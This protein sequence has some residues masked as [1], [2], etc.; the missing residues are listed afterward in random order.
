MPLPGTGLI[1]VD[2]QFVN[3][4]EMNYNYLETSGCIDA[5]NPDLFDPDQTCSDI[6]ANYYPQNLSPTGDCND[7][8][9]LDVMDIITIVNNCILCEPEDCMD[10]FCGDLNQDGS[11]DVMDI[12]LI[13]NTILS[14]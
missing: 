2:P 9:L 6:G 3:P 14:N 8:A 5:G 13:V 10:C 1:T 4:Q 7:D 12:L 11:V